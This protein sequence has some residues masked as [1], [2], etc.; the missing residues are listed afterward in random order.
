MGDFAAYYRGEKEAPYLTLF[1]G[2]NHEASRHMGE[3]P[4]GGW[5]AHN[6]YYLGHQSV[7]Q[8]GG[9]RIGGISGIYKSW[10]A[11]KGHFERYPFSE[12]TLRSHYHVRRSD[13]WLLQQ[14]GVLDLMLS[15]DWPTAA[16]APTVRG[17]VQNLLRT[18]QFFRE[19][20]AKGQLGNPMLNDL[21]LL[22]HK[23]W[24]ASHLHCHYAA[25][26]SAD[27]RFLALDKPLPGRRF[28]QWLSLPATGPRSLSFDPVWL[29]VM[30]THLPSLGYFDLYMGP[31]RPL[32]LVA[33]AP[34]P[35]PPNPPPGQRPDPA[36]TQQL[37]GLFIPAGPPPLKKPKEADPNALNIDFSD[38]D[39]NDNVNHN[40]NAHSAANA[41]GLQQQQQQQ[42]PPNHQPTTFAPVAVNPPILDLKDEEEEGLPGF[43]KPGTEL[44]K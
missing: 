39:D 10:D 40:D 38:E 5:V 14:C 24:I 31:L 19:D 18:K 21:T 41:G 29:Q 2:G 15:H 9:L 43:W 1:I 27:T 28:L 16:T 12:Q 35:F 26:L 34:L 25:L 20:V 3:V 36:Q 23:Y 7:V 37:L 11:D 42:L 33:P 13:V 4:F 30:Q 17:D 32:P 44:A 8:Y 22:P 6:M